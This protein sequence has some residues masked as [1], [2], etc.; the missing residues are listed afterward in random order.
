VLRLVHRLEEWLI[1]ALMAAMTLLTFVQVVLRY[2]FNA[3]LI[4]ALEATTYLF[5]WLVLLGISY[6]VRV[7][8]HIG[9]DMV[10][11]LFGP[12][13][14]RIVGLVAVAFCFLYAGLM[15][16]GASVYIDKMIVLDVEAEDIPLPRWLLGIVLPIG[17]ALLFVRLVTVALGIYAGRRE[18]LADEAEA[19]LRSSAALKQESI[20]PEDPS[21]R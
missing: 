16:Y 18:L 4:W 1:A 10:V 2:V 7:N 8:A 6:G 9:V 17:F 13:W 12:R 21:Q 19:A 11:K 14:R 20:G 5:L 15:V 3:G